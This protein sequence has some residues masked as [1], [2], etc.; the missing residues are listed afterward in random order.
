MNEPPHQNICFALMPSFTYKKGQLWMLEQTHT[1]ILANRA[2]NVDTGF[3]LLFNEK[4]D[5][6]D[7]R[8]LNFPGRVV[9]G[10]GGKW[11]EFIWRPS[12]LVRKGR[13]EPAKML[14][15]HDMVNIEDVSADALPQVLDDAIATVQGAKKFL[16]IGPDAYLKL[17]DAAVEGVDWTE[18]RTALILH[19]VNINVGGL[20]DAYI[21][22]RASLNVPVFYF[23]ATDEPIVAEWFITSKLNKLTS[24][25][26]EGKLVVPGFKAAEVEPPSDL[27][28]TPP[29]APRLNHLTI[30]HPEDSAKPRINMPANLVTMSFDSLTAAQRKP[31]HQ[32]YP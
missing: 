30:L 11:D 23:T 9:T 26:L 22:E 17:F 13:T 1:K 32:P 31:K 5:L 27:L 24:L 18:Y 29:S 12:N 14:A 6:R 8:P 15:T 7:S 10:A 21:V 20:F 4:I 19:E 28:E 16:Q 2:L 25:H 3:T